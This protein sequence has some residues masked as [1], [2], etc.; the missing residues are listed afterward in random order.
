LLKSSW[1]LICLIGIDK[2]K[3]FNPVIDDIVLTTA[4]SI[5]PE[6]PTTRVDAFFGID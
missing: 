1:F 4:E 2:T 5:P 6:T 3:V